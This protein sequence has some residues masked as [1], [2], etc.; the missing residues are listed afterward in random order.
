MIINHL[1]R[2]VRYK[3]LTTEFPTSAYVIRNR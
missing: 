3:V 2:K 1:L